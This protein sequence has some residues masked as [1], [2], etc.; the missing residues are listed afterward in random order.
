MRADVVD[1]YHGDVVDDFQKVFAAGT[2]GI[3]HKATQ[4]AGNT[5]VFYANR[6]KAATDAGLLWAAYHFNT[7]EPV[8]TQVQHF[9]DAAQ[10]DEN[11]AMM[12]DFEDNKLSQMSIDQAL[13]F[14][15]RLAVHV[16][17]PVIYS[18]NRIKDKLPSDPG[19]RAEFGKYR[20]WGCE[21][22]PKWVNV[23]ANHRPLPWPAGPWLWQFT[24]DGIGPQPH[25]VDGITTHG[26]DINQY[27]GDPAVLG[28]DW[29]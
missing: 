9:L 17:R 22:G 10:P 20:L 13:D 14:M 29:V 28:E 25:T 1:M 23:D 6:R 18:G 4:G 15:T 24:G 2:K 26:I 12:L 27:N 7:G 5:D 11:T 19:I 16:K 3:I 21:Y 8:P